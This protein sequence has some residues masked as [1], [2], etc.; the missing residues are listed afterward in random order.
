MIFEWFISNRK[1]L[2]LIRLTKS[3]I[4]LTIL[5]LCLIASLV[6]GTI[7][8]L[9][10]LES[11]FPFSI[12]I[13][14][15]LVLI[16]AFK[17]TKRNNIVGNVFIAM[18]CFVM[19]DLSKK[20]GGIYSMDLYGLFIIPALAYL[21]IGFRSALF[22]L[23]VCLGWTIYIFLISLSPTEAALY[24]NQTLSFPPAYYFVIACIC[25]FFI[26][27][28]IAVF[29]FFNIR[30]LNSINKEKD[31]LQLKTFALEKTEQNLLKS[32]KEL[33]SYAYV[34]SHDLKQ[35]VHN[36][37]SIGNLLQIHIKEQKVNDPHINDYVDTM[38]QETN[39]MNNLIEALLAYSKLSVYSDLQNHSQLVSIQNIV[40][41]FKEHYGDKVKVTS[42]QLPSIHSIE[43][44]MNQLFQNLFSNAIKFSKENQIPEIKIDVIDQSTHWKFSFIDNGIGIDKKYF[45]NIFQPFK[46]LQTKKE[47]PGT[48]IGLAICKK[49]VETHQGKIWVE[50]VFGEGT[51]FHFTLKK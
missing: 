41:S 4:L 36:L 12:F 2:D 33:E 1:N 39:R 27:I 16:I 29:E 46:R 6:F 50:S 37:S 48:G 43:V 14:T 28:I 5:L 10:Y 24:R 21:T 9:G 38:L 11:S 49:I 45:D 35:P 31:K 34:T 42:N 15:V 40:F 25:L 18:F 44:Q 3:K 23:L 51:T 22:W 13:S 7:Q 20:T 26:S 19:F 17:F 47:Y 30:L 8:S 32:N